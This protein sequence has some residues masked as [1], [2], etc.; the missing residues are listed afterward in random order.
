MSEAPLELVSACWLQGLLQ[1]EEERSNADPVA[2]ASASQQV[3]AEQALGETQGSAF[4]PF[5]TPLAQSLQ[6]A[7]LVH[8]ASAQ[9]LSS[10]L[11]CGQSC[12][13]QRGSNL[14]DPFQ[15]NQVENGLFNFL[16]LPENFCPLQTLA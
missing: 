10:S 2:A 11:Q 13:E 7:V 6:D 8:S 1:Y 12:G 14:D 15:Q 5:Q 4:L 9:S 3:V 16:I